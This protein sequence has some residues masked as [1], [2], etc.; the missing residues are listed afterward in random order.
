MTWW[1]LL[2]IAFGGLIALYSQLMGDTAMLGF[3]VFI[4]L[5]GFGLW[6]SVLKGDE[7][8]VKGLQRT[9]VACPICREPVAL[10]DHSNPT[11]F[12]CPACGHK[13]TVR[14]S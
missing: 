11:M 6:V 14:V 13:W 3:G 2:V 10:A 5:G 9:G 1:P 12:K 7:Q 4:A 8:R